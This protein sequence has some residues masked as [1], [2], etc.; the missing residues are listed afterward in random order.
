MDGFEGPVLSVVGKP[1]DQA[2]NELAARARVAG[3]DAEMVLWIDDDAWWPAGT[4]AKL[5]DDLARLPESIVMGSFCR[6]QE[7]DGPV[8]TRPDK[9]DWLIDL[10][11]QRAIQA[12]A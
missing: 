3:T 5:A 12:G 11:M 2:P 7:Y 9:K 10:G 6:R 8:G 1:V 4:V